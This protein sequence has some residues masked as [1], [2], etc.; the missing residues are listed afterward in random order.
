[1][2]SS[3]R[4]GLGFLF[5]LWVLSCGRMEPDI[6]IKRADT[7]HR[8]AGGRIPR[9]KD[10]T[11]QIIIPRDGLFLTA[12]C[13]PEGYDW[14]RDT[15]HGTLKGRLLLLRIGDVRSILAGQGQPRVDTLLALEAGAGKAVSLDADRHQFIG[16][17]LYTQCIT[18]RGTVYRR[19]GQTVL[20]A[21]EPEYLRG[22]LPLGEDIY[23]LSQRMSEGGLI[24]RRNWKQLFQTQDAVLHG[25]LADPAFGRTGALFEDGGEA[26]FLYRNGDGEWRLVRN[27]KALDLPLPA[28]LTKLYDIRCFDGTVCMAC[29]IRQR[30]PVLYIGSKKH[31]LSATTLFP[32]EKLSFQLLRLGGAIRLS[33][34][35]RMNWNQQIYTCLW[36]DSHLLQTAAGRIDWL[37]EKD[38]LRREGRRLLAATANGREY[39]FDGDTALLIMPQCAWEEDG[40]LFLALSRYDGSPVLWV[41]G[42]SCPLPLNGFLTS[43]LHCP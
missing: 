40:K 32:G 10:S 28:H 35:L 7:E 25:S 12:V 2:K 22:I 31:D 18:E 6:H 4:T 42:Q 16:G 29:Q 33:G 38:Y 41:N 20:L 9:G 14:R 15:A 17:H 23:T 43:V 30:Q 36:S 3:I 34:T 26:C 37:G 19:D 8:L 5:F 13:Y 27:G 21:S 39:P 1:M 24:L 11:Q